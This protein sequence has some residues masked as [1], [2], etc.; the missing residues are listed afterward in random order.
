MIKT[1]FVLST[2]V[3][4]RDFLKLLVFKIKFNLNFSFFKFILFVVVGLFVGL[5]FCYKSK[6]FK[7]DLMPKVK[8]RRQKIDI[9]D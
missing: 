5:F 8:R 1:L 3:L 4:N 6:F 2:R 9:D 7:Y